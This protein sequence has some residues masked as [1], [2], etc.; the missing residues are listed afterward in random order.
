[1]HCLQFK[2]NDNKLEG[3]QE[4]KKKKKCKKKKKE[5]EK[6]RKECLVTNFRKLFFLIMR[7]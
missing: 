1:M 4:K 7:T 2:E 5:R 3:T 6:E